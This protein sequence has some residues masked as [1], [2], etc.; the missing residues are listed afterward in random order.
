[1]GKVIPLDLTRQDT[2]NKFNLGY[3]TAWEGHKPDSDLYK[4]NVAYRRGYDAGDCDRNTDT[5]GDYDEPS[6]DEMRE[7]YGDPKDRL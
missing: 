4:N 1:M 2:A 7:I 3:K 6:P 5:D